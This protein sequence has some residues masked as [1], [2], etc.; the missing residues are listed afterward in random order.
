MKASPKT[1]ERLINRR[2]LRHK[3]EALIDEGEVFFCERVRIAFATKYGFN[4]R[5]HYVRQL[6]TF[7]NDDRVSD[8]L[9][10][11]LNRHEKNWAK[12]QYQKKKDGIVK[13]LTYNRDQAVGE[14]DE[15]LDHVVKIRNSAK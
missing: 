12:N 2:L 7:D 9:R 8:V 10:N 15:A 1:L 5:T 4:H 6:R 14:L 11:T 3:I 13:D